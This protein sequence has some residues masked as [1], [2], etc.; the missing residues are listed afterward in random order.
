M[1]CNLFTLRGVYAIKQTGFGIQT[2]THLASLEKKDLPTHLI[3]PLLRSN[4]VSKNYPIHIHKECEH[5]QNRGQSCNVRYSMKP[6][7]LLTALSLDTTN[8]RVNHT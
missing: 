1:I 4:A 7:S 6:I 8:W 5:K 2:T 3:L